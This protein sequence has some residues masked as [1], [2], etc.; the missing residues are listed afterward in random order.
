[1][2]K[3]NLKVAAMQQTNATEGVA[4]YKND[5]AFATF[6][7]SVELG[8][9]VELR[10][11]V[12][13]NGQPYVWIK[14]FRQGLREE[15]KLLLNQSLLDCQMAYLLDV[16]Y[17]EIGDVDANEIEDFHISDEERLSGYYFEFEMLKLIVGQGRDLSVVKRFTST[18]YYEAFAFF[19]NG[20][21]K[22]LVKLDEAVRSFLVSNNLEY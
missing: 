22:F 15:Y 18:S 8:A 6:L 7:K 20:K 21:I 17:A 19:P 11:M 9:K 4:N 1:M 13:K 5:V 3:L 16:P 2:K 10:F 12:D 14:A